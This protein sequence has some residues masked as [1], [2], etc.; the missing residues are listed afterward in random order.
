MPAL[1]LRT[2]EYATSA[3]VAPL[4]FRVALVA[5]HALIAGELR[6][7]PIIVS[8]LRL[9]TQTTAVQTAAR[10]ALY[11]CRGTGCCTP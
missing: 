5:E 10:W 9:G 1:F 3:V 8:G 11:R 6:H 2:V 7:R 4:V